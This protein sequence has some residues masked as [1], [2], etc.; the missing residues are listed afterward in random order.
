MILSKNSDINN[1]KL[2]AE[3][4]LEWLNVGISPSEI[5]V[6][7]FNSNSKKNIIKNIL[8]LT[9][10]NTLDDIKVY[11]FNGLVYNTV[12]DNWG[13]LENKISS[14]NTHISPNLSGLE[15][16]QYILKQLIKEEDVKGYNSKKSLLHQIFRRYSL[17]TNNNLTSDEIKQKSEIIG[18][19]FYDDA[20]RI[21]QNFKSKTIDLRAFDYIRQI[22]LFIY[23][24]EKTDYFKQINYLIAEDVDEMPPIYFDFLKSISKN[25]KDKLIL[26]DNEGGSRC[27]YL[28]AEP[29]ASEKLKTIFN[30]EVLIKNEDNDDVKT[31]VNNILHN[32]RKS[33]TNLSVHS[34]SKRLDMIEHT[35]HLV[36]TLIKSGTSPKEISIITPIQ[37]K[38]LRYTLQYGLKNCNPIFI[39]GNEKLVENPLVKTILT[40]LKISLNKTVDEYELRVILSKILH[41]P[42]KKCK[43]I[44]ESYKENEKLPNIDLA[45]YSEPYK[46]F[47]TLVEV[48][49]KNKNNLSDKAYYIYQNLIDKV[50]KTDLEKFVF[51]LKELQDFE[52]VFD[53]NKPENLEED[54]I[55]QLENSIIS[56]N[57]YSTLEIHEDDLIIS[58]PQKTIDNKIKTKYQ[59]WLDISSSEWIKEDIGPLYNSWVFQKS[60]SKL[61]YS[62]EDNINCSKQ[63]IA[64]ILRKLLNNTEKVIA[65]SSLFDTQGVENFGGIEEYLVA[66]KNT[67][68]TKQTKTFKI[69][70]RDDQ[71]PVLEYQKGQMAISAVP[72]AGKT[73]ILLALIIE[74]MNK[75]IEP[76]NIYV[77]T[78]M[79]SAARNFKDRIKNINPDSTKLPNISTIHGLALRIL[80]ENSNYERIGLNPEFEICDDTQR[81]NIIK[82]LSANLKKSDLEDFDRAISVLKFSG[83]DLNVETNPK[84]KKLLNLSQGSYEDMKVSRFLKFFYSYQDKLSRNNLIDYDD[85]LISSVKLLEENED[86]LKYYQNIC[87]YIIE[88][89]AQDSSSIQQRLIN[90]LSQK[91]KNLIRCGDINQA[92]TTT[93]TNADVEGFKNFIETSQRVDMNRSQRCC[94]GVWKLANKLVKYGNS[95]LKEPFY[96]IYMNPVEGRNPVEKTPINVKIYQ[97]ISEEKIETVKEIKNIL[98]NNPSATIGILL[99]NNYQVNRWADYINN[100]GLVAITRNECLGQKKIFRV[101]FSI[102]KFISNPYDNILCAEAYQ[103]LAECGILKLHM[104]KVISSY[105][106]DFISQDNDNIIDADLSRFHWEM[107]YWL[108]FPE[109]TIDE[110]ALMIGLTYFSEKLE[111]SNI[112]LIST[113]CAKLNTGTFSETVQ[114]LENLSERPTLSGFKFFSEDEEDLT[115]GKIQIMTM[116]KSKG[117]EFDYVFLPEMSEKNLTLKIDSLKLKKNSNFLEN[118]R[119][120][121][122]QYSTKSEEE[123]KSFLISE[124]YR[125]LYV[126]ITRAKKRLYFSSSVTETYFGKQR[127]IEQSVIFEDILK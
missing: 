92:I 59:F 124:N 69:I 91:H 15:V 12:L 104:D 28:C 48:L 33:L 43:N 54:I 115:L 3:K 6:L 111:K 123:L 73:T 67:T 56:E 81:G 21:I 13:L 45:E 68:D 75:G 117:D 62:I 78:Y 80:K 11:S 103:A 24:F 37:D 90:L 52:K 77:L 19:S 113:L 29:M 39:S 71:K 119:G 40:I 96:E 41:I 50:E 8:N 60:W 1:T 86:I 100:S 7:T 106:F 93:F 30:E 26:T 105:E 65:L 49:S 22:P 70:P 120:L 16:S 55:T 44:L 34:L 9:N 87:E 38:M 126:A 118:I 32:E 101:I 99:R 74:L 27:G 116:H 95:K 58:T 42:I 20:N 94:E 51:F 57:P 88:D 84:I 122:P 79:E 82:S 98:S 36:N 125:L 53:N 18:E 14:G 64:K 114:K 25:L 127:E 10:Q 35:V 83:C 107:N 112:Y 66:E 5:L 97:N 72:G 109:L 89:E 17:I 102:L 4:Y 61:S 85:I 2:I 110:L 76:E 46:N 31:L 23:I 121:N 63:K 47:K 108:S